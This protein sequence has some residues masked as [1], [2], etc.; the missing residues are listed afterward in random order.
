MRNATVIVMGTVLGLAACSSTA[1]SSNPGGS[2]TTN[3]AGVTY[4]AS[5]AN[6]RVY[7]LVDMPSFCRGQVSNATEVDATSIRTTEAQPVGGDYEVNVTVPRGGDFNEYYTCTFGG[8][9]R[10]QKMTASTG[11]AAPIDVSTL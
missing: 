3:E 6:S 1:P 4:R 2:Y 9:G 5:S 7:P 11:A 10:F 8:D